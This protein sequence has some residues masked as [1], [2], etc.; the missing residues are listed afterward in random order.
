MQSNVLGV[1]A[2]AFIL[3][4][5]VLGQGDATRAATVAQR[6]QTIRVQAARIAELE[7]LVETNR[8]EVARRALF[9]YSARSRALNDRYRAESAEAEADRLQGDVADL[10]RQDAADEVVRAGGGKPRSDF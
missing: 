8:S 7:A 5:C 3:S 4:A 1:L 2:P 6:D 9:D 10:R